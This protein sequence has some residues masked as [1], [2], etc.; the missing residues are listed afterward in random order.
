MLSVFEFLWF[1][2]FTDTVN[3]LFRTE[4]DVHD[5]I[6]FSLVSLNLDFWIWIRTLVFV[7]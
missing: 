5:S 2:G 7:N 3:F 4:E 6:I 1:E